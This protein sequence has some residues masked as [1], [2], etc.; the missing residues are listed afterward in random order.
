MVRL[1]LGFITSLFCFQHVDAT[2]TSMSEIYLGSREGDPGS[3]VENVST[4]HGDYTEVEVDLTVASPDSLILSRFYSSRDTLPIAS[5]GGW[6]FNPQCFLTMQKDPKGKTYSS[7]EGKFER[8]FVYVGNPDGSILTYVGWKNVTNP[9]KSVL[10]KIDAEMECVGIANTARGDI[11]AWTN[12]KNNELYYNPQNDSFELLL[13]TEGKRFYVKN[14]TENFYFITHEILPS[15][16][17]IFYEFNEKN[18]LELIKETNA[19]E[20]KIFAWI[21]IQYGNT[22]HIETSDG[23]TVDYQFQQDSSG[24]QLLTSVI[25]SHKP[26]LY[27]QYHVDEDHALLIKKTM[28]DGR[29]VDVEYYTD[30]PNKHKVRSVVRPSAS[31]DTSTIQFTYDQNS[32]VVNGPGKQKSVHRFNDDLQFV[33]LEQYLDGSIYR[34]HQKSWGRKSD[35]GNLISTSIADGGNSIFYH[36]SFTYDRKENIIEERECGD[37]V[38]T[39]TIALE[40]NDE[41]L[42][43]NQDGHVKNYSYFSGKTSHGFFQKDTKGTG[44]KCWYKKG[45]NLLIKKLILTKGS[46]DS[47][48]ENYDSGIKQRFFYIYNDDAALIKVVVDDG[49]AG[50]F[51]DSYCVNERLIT[52]ISPKQEMPN[53]GAPEVI[54]QKYSTP[55]GK[56]ETLIK[57]TINHFDDQGNISAQ[58]IYDAN[59]EHQYTIKKQYINGLLVFETDPMGHE[60]HY[61]YDANQNLKTETHLDTGISS[62][63]GYDLKNRLVRT[64]EKDSMDNQFETQISY[65]ASGYK[66]GERDRYGNHTLYDNDALGRLVRITYPEAS[67]GLHASLSPTY[68]YTYDLFDNLVSVTDPKGKILTQ[69]YT[70]K[71]KPREINYADGTKEVF[72]YDSGGNLHHHYCRNGLLEV[73]E[74]DYIGRPSK[75]QYF[76]KNSTNSSYPFKEISCNY[77]TFHKNY[78]TDLQGKKTSYTY[79][80]AGRLASIKKENQ[81]IDFSYDSLGR[82]QSVKKWK[83]AQDFTLEVKEYDLLDRVIEERTEDPSGHILFRKKFVYNDAGN[84]EQVIGYPH[85]QESVLMKYESDGFGRVVK[86]TNAAGNSTQI[87]YDNAYVNDWGQ[88]GS[89]RTVIDPMGNRT[90]EFFDN[91]DHLI[92]VYKKDKSGR[93][94]S[95]ID[96]AYDYAGNKILEKAAIFS[97]DRKSRDFE[98][99][100][101]YNQGDQLETITVGKGSSQ[102]RVTRFEYNSYGELTKKFYSGAQTP[103][104]Y[105]YDNYCNLEI[106]SYKEGKN[107]EH[108]LCYDSNKNLS[109]IKCDNLLLSYAY[110][111][112]EWL[113]SETV[114]DEFGSYQISRT[115]DGEGKVKTLKFP[116]GSYVEYS[117]EGPFV[118]SLTR[119]NKDKKEL[120]THVIASRDQMGNIIE[121]ILP[122]HLGA[123]TQTWDEAGRRVCITTDFF[124]DKVLRY[125]SLDNIKTRESYFDDA[126]FEAEYGYNSLQQ[127]ISEKGYFEHNYSYDSIDNRLKK[128]GTPYKVNGLNELLEAE[129]GIYTF[130]ANGNVATKVVNGKTWTYQSNPL[131]QIVS[132]KDT[133][134]GTITFTYDLKGRRFSKRIDYKGKKRILRF[135]YLDDTEIGCIDEKGVIVE[136]KIPSN[137]NNPESPAIAV[138]IKREAFVP[139]YDLQGNIACLLDPNKRQVVESYRYSIYGEEKIFNERGKS[140]SDSSIGNPWRYRGKRVDKEAGL[141]YFG[142]RYY[143]PEVGR[144]ISPDPMGTIDGPNV[145]AFVHNN[146][147]KYVD[148]F[149]F[150]ST[151]DSNCGCT[152]H[153]HPGWHNAPPDCICICG[154]NGASE[155]ASGSYRSKRGS[156][157][158]SPLG[159]ISHGVVDYLVGS[160]HDLQTA[161]A[162]VGS[163]E[164]EISLH[165]RIQMI[166]AVEQSQMRQMVEVGSLVRG[167][168]DIDESNTVYQSFRSNTTVGL[169]LASLVAGGYGAFKGIIGFSKLAR[170]PLKMTKLDGLLRVGDFRYSKLAANHF[171]ETIKSGKNIGRLLRPYMRSP[172]TINEIMAARRPIPDPRGF[173]G[174][175]RWDVPG[176][177][178]GSEGT[179]E[180]VLD[181]HTGIIGHF[182]FGR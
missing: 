178:R 72:R 84:L 8:T 82:T 85:H 87:I 35:A 95:C 172:H 137:P 76:R 75:V 51:K 174:G 93:L 140:V 40:V 60:A 120:Y 145:Y 48:E 65:D 121:E 37:V 136:L 182:N 146:P 147:I 158:K 36:K 108:K 55:D 81:K 142:Y 20:N 47:E 58:E 104:T 166:E 170:M 132:I 27:Y 127:L 90:E 46:L 98:I 70:V 106:V 160:L 53:V 78:E 162:Y 30:K 88:K 79:D 12:W 130:H 154:K 129:G 151:I 23:K 148:Y 14:P 91:D 57:K 9:S 116:D 1:I 7:A 11:G 169:E 77:S 4:I 141:I 126:Y 2:L 28:P 97:E 138:E 180:L 94:L 128:D 156:D 21:K 44:I 105:Q 49:K 89:K 71:G 52:N 125:D 134:Q 80:G 167:M 112:N 43:T 45:T 41:G 5:L 19:S 175:L 131:N 113:I 159:G 68:T 109:S 165:E 69:A 163:A 10:F 64:V 173:K 13:C 56:V 152:E 32:T 74:Y 42:I 31:D 161:A 6:R 25:R 59:N 179:W 62:E 61:S 26:N 50:D 155:G 102:E 149:G 34:I 38:G 115:Y 133:D 86:A 123:Q 17:K 153:D 114:K 54:E 150:N 168:L 124:Q 118:K 107:V 66:S 176:T 122:G 110:D 99:E 24:V 143:D 117:Y 83:S 39:G 103:I 92:L 100:Y 164:L 139:I 135:L 96:T 15:G 16:N 144:W 22:I 101:A 119:F 29:F 171:N 177:F 33:A 67:N 73:F 181:P 157:I 3:I 111:E 18:Q 63:Y